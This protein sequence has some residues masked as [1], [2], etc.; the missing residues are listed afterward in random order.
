LTANR[1]NFFK[2]KRCGKSFTKTAWYEKHTAKC[3]KEK[4]P[5]KAVDDG[6]RN[7]DGSFKAGNKAGKGNPHW[8]KLRQYREDYLAVFRE[9][10]TPERMKNV[11]LAMIHK[12]LSDGDIQA[13]R[14]LLEY[15]MGRPVARIEEEVEGGPERK[16]LQI[17]E[18]LKALE[19]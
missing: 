16:A 6:D 15:A 9:A 12:A 10:F 7:P 1:K 14:T 5:V 17:A 2:C 11:T 4:K 18:A 3:K 13:C 19:L 8:T